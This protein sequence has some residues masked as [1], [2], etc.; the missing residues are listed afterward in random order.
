MANF[1][2]AFDIMINHEGGYK[3]TDIKGDIGGITYAGI[4][5]RSFPYWEGWKHIDENSQESEL[6]EALVKILYKKEFWGK[7]KGDEIK[8]QKIANTIF[9]FSVNVGVVNAVKRIQ[10]SMNIPDIDGIIG[11]QT[12]NQLNLLDSKFFCAVF[13]MEKIKHYVA[14]CNKNPTQNKFLLGWINRTIEMV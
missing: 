5:R 6:M 7:I 12:L 8:L 3:L 9:D 14:I 11:K 13:A 4:T 10:S 2:E 1:D